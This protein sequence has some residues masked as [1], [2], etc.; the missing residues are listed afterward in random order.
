MN[1]LLKLQLRNVFHEKVFYVCLALLLTSPLFSFIGSLNANSVDSYK[2]FPQIMTFLSSELSLIGM[3]FVCLFTTFD[4]SSG[5][6]KNIIAR[7]Y[8]KT[9]VLF[10]KYIASLIGLFMM[11][12]ITII[13]IFTLFIKNGVGYDGDMIFLLINNVMLIITQVIMFVTLS[14]VLEKNGS[15]IIASLFIPTIIPTVLGLIDTNLKLNIS[16]FW[17]GNISNSF[18]SNPN[19]SNLWY[20]LL[21]YI[22]YIIMFVIIGSKLIKNKEV[23]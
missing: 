18:V 22:I 3:I 13:F 10:S 5:T 6:L 7:G 23:K 12:L 9:Q 17:L 20:S 11:Y 15:A 16:R 14:F 19:L 4:Y 21:G 2:V 8:T 1:R